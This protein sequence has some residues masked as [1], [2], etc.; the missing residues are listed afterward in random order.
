MSE[1]LIDFAVD[2]NVGIAPLTVNF[3]GTKF[4]Y[5]IVYSIWN[6]GDGNQETV[7]GPIDTVS[8]IYTNEGK[9]TVTLTVYGQ[10]VDD[11]DQYRTISLQK[12]LYI[13]VYADDGRIIRTVNKCYNFFVPSDYLE[14]KVSQTTTGLNS[15]E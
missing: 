7:M 3:D 1:S 2:K 8:H 5:N 10:F 13:T 14:P 9:Y 11:T 4:V 12:K 15:N 6:F